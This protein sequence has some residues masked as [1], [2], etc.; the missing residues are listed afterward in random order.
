MKI[1]KTF[2]VGFTLYSQIWIGMVSAGFSGL[3]LVPIICF[4]LYLL[5]G[6]VK[7][8]LSLLYFLLLSSI[9]II[10]QFIISS[11]EAYQSYKVIF[12][13]TK[14][15]LYTWLGYFLANDEVKASKS[16]IVVLIP[17]LLFS[18]LLA[19]SHSQVASVNERLFI[20]V[21]NP[22]W[23]SR[24]VFEFLLIY[25]LFQSRGKSF[26]LIFVFIGLYITYISGSK[27]ALLSFIIV[28][29]L[30]LYNEKVITKK[31]TFSVIIFF[32]VMLIYAYLN[33]DQESF[34]YQRF[35]LPVP[36]SVSED[37]YLESRVIVWPKTIILFFEQ[38][39][40]SL[41]FGNG[42]GEFGT[43]YLGQPSSER[44]YPHNVIL[45]LLVEFGLVPTSILI[46]YVFNKYMNTKTKFKYLFLYFFINA[47]F[48]GDLLLNEFMFFYFG[49]ILFHQKIHFIRRLN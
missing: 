25:F 9:V 21:Y 24:I 28:M 46:V 5:L 26:S 16:I 18:F 12:I 44:I 3:T 4:I 6:K 40:T 34:F 48:S 10:L 20:G 1:N 37:I 49:F 13:L 8:D 35:L 41:L 47:N 39:V 2:V 14:L 17:F 29:F 36:D 38:E 27:G 11:M 31:L 42:L 32:I 22:I 23:V 7:V 19:L 45:E 30:Y 33:L 43:F 15:L